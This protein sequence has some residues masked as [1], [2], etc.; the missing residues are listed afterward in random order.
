MVPLGLGLVVDDKHP[1]MLYL[2]SLLPD[3][4]KVVKITLQPG[5]V[6]E[7]ENL[8]MPID[9]GQRNVSYFV[10]KF[11]KIK[12]SDQ[13]LLGVSIGCTVIRAVLFAEFY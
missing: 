12:V 3:Q 11:R 6:E 5:D 10:R 4:K 9:Y 7:L 8:R 1:F 13:F 2:S